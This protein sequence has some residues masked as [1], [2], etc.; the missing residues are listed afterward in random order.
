M[1]TRAAAAVALA[2]GDRSARRAQG[3]DCACVDPTSLEPGP[4]GSPPGGGPSVLL[5]LPKRTQSG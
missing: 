5:S 2:A 4:V 1:W 3:V